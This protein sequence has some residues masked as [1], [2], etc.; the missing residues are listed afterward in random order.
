MNSRQ[1]ELE[2]A[3]G[4]GE[5]DLSAIARALWRNRWWVLVPTLGVA[6][7][8]FVGVNLLTPR[9][10]SEAR[11]LIEGRE[12]VFLRPEA[13]KA[14]DRAGATVDQEAIT[15]QV[16][17]ALSR[18]LARQVIHQLK[19][20]G[21]PEFDPVLRASSPVL[22]ILRVVGLA[23][24]P[25]QMT[26]EER[27]LEA[28]YDR[29]AVFPIDKSRV[30][31]IQFQS[32]DP[33]LAAQVANTVADAFLGLDRAARQDQ[34]RAAGQWLAGEI[35]VL[36][37][38]VAE[39]EAKVENFRASSNLFVG[40]NNTS[41]S[42][43]Q[44]GEVNSQVAAARSQKADAESRARFIRELLKSGKSLE[45]AEFLN[46]ELI[47]RL[48]EQRVTLRAQLAEQS[49]TLLE[50]HPRIKELK[51]QIADLDQQIRSEAEKLVRSLEN[52]ARIAGG[53]VESLTGNLEQLK[54]Q[55]ASTN[56]Q[57][58]ELRALEREAK[59][60]RDLL[61]SYLAKYREAT[62]RDSLNT[63]PSD[64]RIIS[65]A[66]VSNTPY[67]PKKLPI[68]LIATLATL[69]IAV[70]A[71]TTGELLAS[72]GYRPT[73]G[74]A[75]PAASADLASDR[76][77]ADGLADAAGPALAADAEA[78]VS[79]PDVSAPGDSESEVSELDLE[80]ATDPALPDDSITGIATQIRRAGAAGRM[81]AVIGAARNVGTTLTAVALARSLAESAR[82]VLIDLALGA[83]NIAAFALD[84]TGPGITDLVRGNASFGEIITRDRDSRVHIVPAGRI[85]VDSAAILGSERLKI[86][87]T[88]LVRAYDHVV[89]DAGA[90]A[91][92]EPVPPAARRA[93]LV[94]TGMADAADA[95]ADRLLA[96]GFTDVTIYT[97]RPPKPNSQRA[98]TLVA[99]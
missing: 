10:Q 96:A 65:R 60:Q 82:V 80:T 48:S 87:L 86:G 61:E 47:R 45:S 90:L 15:S 49:S 38:K 89:I 57:D 99:A 20:G 1:P 34:T 69:F 59:A 66:V 14:A 6:A 32:G 64:V 8:A 98:D 67:F 35:E 72:A 40:T 63:M 58:I 95:V 91:A 26:A 12:N 77:D 2:R 73:A 13:E 21:W 81:V 18:D 30:I 76:P 75:G 56:E 41:L 17:L 24:D 33:E 9:Y 85:D 43:Q 84:R 52:D 23:K 51:A 27:V 79:A 4:D 54:R 3:L 50:L 53:R 16:Q 31:G 83:P 19:L 39:A 55:A 36:R 25:L 11:I 88:A 22:Q 46:S 42:N 44:L 78:N 28:Y 94:A 29:L 7:A 70:G 68:V 74:S 92:A 93:V 71:I 37:Q 97:G 62:A 5:L